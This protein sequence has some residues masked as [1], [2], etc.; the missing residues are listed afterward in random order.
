MNRRELARM[1][2]H[3]LL[4]PEATPAEV[5]RLCREALMHHFASVC[6]NPIFVPMATRKLAGSDV[7]VCTVVGFPLGATSTAMKVCEAEMAIA[8]GA[9]EIDMVIPVGM[10]KAGKLDL[11]RG[12]VAAVAAVC[13]THRALLKVIIEAG[14][15]T[16]AEKVTACELCKAAHADFV[17]TSTGFAKGGATV[18]DVALMRATVGP[19]LG[20]KAAG[21]IG[22]YADALAM[23]EAGATR[24]GAS[25]G[26]QI[27]EGLPG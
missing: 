17:K 25:R 7:A 27:V 26:V 13:H 11:V 4:K 3:T 15:L 2:D 1:I 8:Q 10:L 5:E 21:G 20:V 16:D 22:S 14:L 24:I 12:D 18:E 6:I 23:I 19:A 9:T